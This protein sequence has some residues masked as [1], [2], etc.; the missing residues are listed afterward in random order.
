MRIE[1]FNRYAE[2]KALR[3]ACIEYSFSE[4]NQLLA[5]M[6]TSPAVIDHKALERELNFIASALGIALA[7]YTPEQISRFHHNIIL[8]DVSP[9]AHSLGGIV[10]NQAQLKFERGHRSILIKE[11]IAGLSL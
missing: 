2:F 11:Q 4:V 5:G 1:E 6:A 10:V 8:N 3:T 7:Y 9:M